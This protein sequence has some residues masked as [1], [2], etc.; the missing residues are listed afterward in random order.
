MGSKLLP[1]QFGLAR[2]SLIEQIPMRGSRS[3]AQQY[4]GEHS[5]LYKKEI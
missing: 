5:L 1:F 3:K 2:I 4:E